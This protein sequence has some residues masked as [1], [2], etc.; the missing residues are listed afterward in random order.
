MF[1]KQ[2]KNRNCVAQRC[3]IKHAHIVI[4]L[5][6]STLYQNRTLY[7][8]TLTWQY[9]LLSRYRSHIC[10]LKMTTRN[11]YLHMM[12]NVRVFDRHPYK[13]NNKFDGI[14]KIKICCTGS[15]WM[16]LFTR[17]FV[18]FYERQR[19]FFTIHFSAVIVQKSFWI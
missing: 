1:F 8:T 9:M 12:W 11:S 6:T 15:D 13:V 5:Y 4:H 2:K 14:R 16:S 17:N 7:M 10:S 3:K 19:S 18:F